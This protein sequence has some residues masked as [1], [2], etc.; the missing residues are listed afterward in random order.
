MR[1]TALLVPLL[2]YTFVKCSGLIDSTF[3]VSE[4][5]EST[6]V[7]LLDV[8]KRCILSDENRKHNNSRSKVN[9]YR[10]I[11]RAILWKNALR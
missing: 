9:E 4:S 6:A 5:L 2:Q 11:L 8:I 7:T 1:E 3:H 10:Y